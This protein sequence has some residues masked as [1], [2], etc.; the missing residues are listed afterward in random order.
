MTT[1]EYGS[2]K[3][4]G[5]CACSRA[6]VRRKRSEWICQRCD[7]ME[8]ADAARRIK[9]KKEGVKQK[10]GRGGSMGK[11][12]IDEPHAICGDSMKLLPI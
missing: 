2:T 6:G 4:K 1:G 7:D 12:K 10:T 9:A 3:A 11:K 8:T 5:F